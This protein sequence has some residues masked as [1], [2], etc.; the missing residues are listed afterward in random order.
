MF[1]NTG[2]AILTGPGQNNWDLS[3][4]KRTRVGG[5][6]EDS[7]LEFRAE[8]FNAFNHP[9]FSNPGTAISSPSTFGIITSTSVGPRVFQFALR[10]VF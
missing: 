4:T 8:A 9:Q 5:I 7:N 1:G 3:I 2:R 6:H 10:Y